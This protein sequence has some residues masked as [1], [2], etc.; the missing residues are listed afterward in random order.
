MR[1]E[2]KCIR[3]REIQLINT[4][5]GNRKNDEVIKVI[6][7]QTQSAIDNFAL[8]QASINSAWTGSANKS[9]NEYDIVIANIIADVIIMIEKQ[10]KQRVK[11]G[12]ILILSGII[13]KYFDKVVEKFNDFD[14][15]EIIKKDEWYTLVLQ[16]EQNVSK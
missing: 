15:I 13:D 5:N 1:K 7:L 6:R 16:K 3:A 2:K 11:S 12:G 9:Q 8:N 4:E 10:L 14:K